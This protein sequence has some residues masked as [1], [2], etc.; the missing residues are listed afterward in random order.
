[1]S[2]ESVHHGKKR[3][4]SAIPSA[5]HLASA[6]LFAAGLI[7]TET[8]I[9]AAGTV[10]AFTEE[11]VA[12]VT[13]ASA[14]PAPPG[15]FRPKAEEPILRFTHSKEAVL[16]L[17]KELGIGQ[18]SED[19]F[20][21][22]DGPPTIEYMVRTLSPLLNLAD[23]D[24]V[25]LQ[26]ASAKTDGLAATMKFKTY[27]KGALVFTV[28]MKRNNTVPVIIQTFHSYRADNRT[29]EQTIRRLYHT[30]LPGERSRSFLPRQTEFRAHNVPVMPRTQD[31]RILGLLSNISGTT[32]Y[33]EHAQRFADL[34]L[35]GSAGA[36]SLSL[37]P[38]KETDPQGGGGKGTVAV[39]SIRKDGRVG[40]QLVMPDRI[41]P[42]GIE[43]TYAK[44]KEIHPNLPDA[45]KFHVRVADLWNFSDTLSI[46]L[47]D[48]YLPQ[49][50]GWMLLGNDEFDAT[51]HIP[52][53][54]IPR[55]ERP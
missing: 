34:L 54:W 43:E 1:M 27:A 46:L 38:M 42:A 30:V 41:T 2:S 31:P 22:L 39:V 7:G 29:A 53:G 33:G 23:V 17:Y 37:I 13:L 12:S 6:V 32:V 40:I 3:F 19:G 24:T 47:P 44:I 20:I 16:L 48:T 8:R 28:G 21:V 4:G 14:P 51:I 45:S 50:A 26:T 35:A 49:D 18:R 5:R 25:H 52:D 9:D 10:R 15:T 55:K 11:P 36:E